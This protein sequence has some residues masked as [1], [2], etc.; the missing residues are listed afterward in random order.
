MM[1]IH[2]DDAIAFIKETLAVIG[3]VM[4]VSWFGYRNL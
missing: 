4:T 1:R 3:I 2:T